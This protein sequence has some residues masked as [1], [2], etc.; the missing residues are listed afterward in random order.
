MCLFSD[1]GRLWCRHR[2]GEVFQHQMS[3]RGSR[4]ERG[5][6]CDD[7]TCS[8]DAWWWPNSHCW[9]SIASGI[10]A[11]S[12]LL[13]AIVK[14]SLPPFSIFC[15]CLL[16]VLWAVLESQL[17]MPCI[18][19]LVEDCVHCFEFPLDLWHRK[20]IQSIKK[21]VPLI[22]WTVLFQHKWRRTGW[23]RFTWKSH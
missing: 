7:C 23:P 13:A 4:A 1:G 8:E 3:L 2:N 6:T 16:S 19:T 12:R 9:H 11:G 18:S 22:L 10:S 14:W 17:R 15:C 21:P 20:G 5:G